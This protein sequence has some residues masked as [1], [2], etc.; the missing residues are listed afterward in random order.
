M[1]LGEVDDLVLREVSTQQSWFLSETAAV[2][3]HCYFC[4]VRHAG[5][6]MAR[7]R[8]L[9][10]PSAPLQGDRLIER[11]LVVGAHVVELGEV[12]GRNRRV[13]PHILRCPALHRA[14]ASLPKEQSRKI[15]PHAAT[16]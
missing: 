16:L 14:R 13:H 7:Q 1:A 8:H 10:P 6:Q 12:G 5:A 11:A 2:V 4:C 9:R 15:L 3:F